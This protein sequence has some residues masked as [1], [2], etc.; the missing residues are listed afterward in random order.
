MAFKVKWIHGVLAVSVTANLFVG[1]Y[2]LGKELA[3]ER[4]HKGKPPYSND[5]FSMR[6][7]ASYLPDEKRDELRALMSDHR[8]GLRENFRGVRDIEVRVRAI[9]MAETVDKA[10]LKSALDELEAKTRSLHGPI[11]GIL[12]DIVADLDFETRQ[13][14]G[15]DIYQRRKEWRMKRRGGDHRGPPPPGE[16]RGE[17]PRDGLRDGPGRPEGPGGP[18]MPLP[19][20]EDWPD[21]DE[22]EERPDDKKPQ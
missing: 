4:H 18:G 13:K 20:G 8:K 6:K 21:Q 1:G 12:L 22:P 17:G 11:R 10:A 19:P 14:L 3:P 2:F 5:I 9:L 15:Q 16:P 7:L